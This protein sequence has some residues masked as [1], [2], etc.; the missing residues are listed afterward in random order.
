[1]GHAATVSPINSGN[2]RRRPARR[3]AATFVPYST[4]IESAWASEA[5]SLGTKERKSSHQPAELTIAGAIPDAMQYV[6]TTIR[7]AAGERFQE[8]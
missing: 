8:S 3:G 5:M 6:L 4:W 2:A 7:L 1:Y